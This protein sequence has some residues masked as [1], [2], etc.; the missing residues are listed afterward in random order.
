MGPADLTAA[1]AS[2]ADIS[3]H[4]LRF[5]DRHGRPDMH[6]WKAVV[7]RARST[8][9]RLLATGVSPGDRVAM[10]Y[11][12]GPA[13]FDAF[14]GT[15]LAGAVP[16]PL[17]PPVRLGR[18]DEYH[19][20]TAKMIEVVGAVVVL[21]DPSILRLLGP[22][23]EQSR[24]ALGVLL[25]D[26]LKGG[27]PAHIAA[28]PDQLGLVQF[29]SGTTG[30][31][32]AVALTHR[33]LM[34]QTYALQALMLQAYPED[35][36]LPHSGCSWLPLYHD[37]GLIGCVFPALAHGASLTLIR[38]EHFIAR[39]A[40]W[41][42]AMSD[43]QATISVAPNFAYALC[44]ERIQDA[45]LD[46]VDLSHWRIGLNGAEPVA[47][48]TLTAFVD[49]FS[50]WGL[51]AETLSPVYGLSEAALAVTFSDLKRPFSTRRYDR[52]AL[53]MKGRALRDED[54]RAH[55]SL[56]RPLPGFEVAIRNSTG[57]ALPD[58]TLGH[59]WAKGP[60]LM[61][62]YLNDPEATQ[63][64]LHQ[65]W[66]KT[67]DLGFFDEGELF[68]TGRAKDLILLRGRNHE[69][70]VIEEAVQHVE[71]VRRGCTA[72]VSTLKEGE[73]TERLMLFIETPR[74]GRTPDP[75][76]LT[77]QCAKAVREHV[78]LTVDQ[79]VILSPG[80]L[81]RTSSGKI[82]RAETLARHQRGTLNAPE[83]IGWWRLTRHLLHSAR[84]LRRS[85][86]S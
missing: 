64:A 58:R 5:L 73:A 15:L 21:T 57:E 47:P 31:P 16:V 62:G 43:H 3:G 37:M 10:V 17:Y 28:R 45:E 39:P 55:V 40:T 34:A 49:R 36:H 78:G 14:F 26:D 79:I 1:L 38:P 61:R 30:A 69:P 80:T 33:A 63:S 4:G 59:I 11:P 42:R 76:A 22:T 75:E 20:R 24:P 41:L 60:S 19:P 77:E 72:A 85:R 48:S 65:G 7:D 54:G 81:P 83:R 53:S 12:T 44:T 46:G 74:R 8:A 29:S 6:P 56:G 68:V 67:G 9:G 32:K 70:Q 52:E 35:E 25:L 86:S 71:G 51:R 66:L 27:E 18:L 13:F 2:V 23:I 50:P 84:A 82:R